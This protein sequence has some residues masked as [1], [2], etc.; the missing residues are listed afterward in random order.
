MAPPVGFEPTTFFLQ[1]IHSLLNGPDYLIPP[2]ADRVYSLY[3]FILQLCSGL[4][5]SML[6]NLARDNP[7]PSGAGVP[8][9]SPILHIALLLSAAILTGSRSTI[10]LQGNINER[11]NYIMIL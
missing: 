10:E 11:T 7:T 4:I 2:R 5:L 9:I 8:R 1:L 6:R 3:T